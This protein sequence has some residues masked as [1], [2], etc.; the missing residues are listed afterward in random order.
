MVICTD[1][2]VSVHAHSNRCT[3]FAFGTRKFV[4]SRINQACRKYSG[5]KHKSIKHLFYVQQVLYKYSS[6]EMLSVVICYCAHCRMSYLATHYH[7]MEI[8]QKALS[9]C[10]WVV[11]PIAV[12]KNFVMYIYV[13]HDICNGNTDM[14][15]RF[16]FKFQMSA[17]SI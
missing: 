14:K 12:N 17:C 9:R 2:V 5:T 8:L 11:H 4:T 13:P 1:S 6:S 16:P 7:M 3:A 10:Q 15:Q